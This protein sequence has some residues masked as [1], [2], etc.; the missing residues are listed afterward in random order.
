MV[1]DK[2]IVIFFFIFEAILKII[3]FNKLISEYA[4][5]QLE[6]STKKACFINFGELICF[7]KKEVFTDFFTVNFEL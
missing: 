7:F 1:V 5:S 6:L 2:K 3:L 4:K